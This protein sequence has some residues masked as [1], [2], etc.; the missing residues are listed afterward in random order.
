MNEVKEKTPAP[1]RVSNEQ[2]KAIIPQETQ[3]VNDYDIEGYLE[4]RKEF[5]TKLGSKMIEG[6]DYHVIQNKK[7]LAKGGAE[8]IASIFGWTATFEKDTATIEAFSELKGVV[9]YICNLS[10]GIQVGQGRGAAVLSTNKG[11]PNKTIKMAQKSAFIDAVLRASGLSDIFT[12]DLEDMPREQISQPNFNAGPNVT[13]PMPTQSKSTGVRATLKQQGFIL[14]LAE[15][16]GVMDKITPK[17]VDEL[18]MMG[19]KKWV[20]KLK[21][22][23]DKKVEATNYDQPPFEEAEIIFDQK[24]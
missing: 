5:I 7:S 21:S 18:D 9:A 15:Q 1:T 13:N 16:K 24:N 17:M 22:M 10:K 6:K 2:S 4:K 12:Q 11:D 14:K 20:D 23:P 3:L 8:K 19:A